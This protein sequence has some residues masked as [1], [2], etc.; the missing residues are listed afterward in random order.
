[1]QVEFD[2]VQVEFEFDDEALHVD[3]KFNFR[4]AN[5]IDKYIVLLYHNDKAHFFIIT[6]HVCLP[7]RKLIN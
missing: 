1:M 5:S 6:Y 4:S 3:T 2:D 7:L